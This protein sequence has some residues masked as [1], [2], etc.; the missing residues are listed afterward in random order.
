MP[1]ENSNKFFLVFVPLL[2]KS[3]IKNIVKTESNNECVTNFWSLPIGWTAKRISIISK[4]K[5]PTIKN[6]KSAF[7]SLK[8]YLK[9]IT[10]TPINQK[11]K[12]IAAIDL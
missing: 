6:L 1:I 12:K 11:N 10:P 7:L 8:I 3:I 2:V 5:R 9:M 4:I